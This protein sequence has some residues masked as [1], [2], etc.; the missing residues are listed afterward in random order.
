[1]IVPIEKNGYSQNF[2]FSALKR[3]CPGRDQTLTKTVEF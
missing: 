3:L 1:M 2:N